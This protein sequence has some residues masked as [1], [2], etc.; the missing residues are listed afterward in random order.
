MK[1]AVACDHGALVLKTRIKD[2]LE[3]EGYEVV[4][5]GTYDNESCDYPDFAYKAALALKEGVVDRAIVMCTTGVGMSIVMNK[6]KNVRCALVNDVTVAKLTREHNDTNALALGALTVDC[7]KAKQICKI[8][9]ETP[10]SNGE[11]HVRRLEKIAKI[12][13]KEMR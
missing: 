8:W 1:V 12:E 9:L 13:E 7:E 6:V 2:Y 11:R 10:F 4:D 3:K 5:C